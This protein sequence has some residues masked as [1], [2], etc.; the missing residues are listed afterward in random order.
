MKTGFLV[1]SVLLYLIRIPSYAAGERITSSEI[2]NVLKDCALCKPGTTQ[3]RAIGI[4]GGDLWVLAM[5]PSAKSW[6]ML[7][8]SISAGRF[9]GANLPPAA[10]YV[11]LLTAEGS[12]PI[13][14]QRQPVRSRGHQ[15]RLVAIGANGSVSALESAPSDFYPLSRRGSRIVGL[16]PEGDIAM[17]EA[18]VVTWRIRSP[19]RIA[20]TLA[21]VLDSGEVVIADMVWGAIQVQNPSDGSRNARVIEIADVRQSVVEIDKAVSRYP[22]TN[23][24]PLRP[25]VLVASAQGPHGHIFLLTYPYRA[26]EGVKVIE[27]GKTGEYRRTIRAVLPSYSLGAIAY[28]AASRERLCL[29][30]ITGIV[31]C[32]DVAKG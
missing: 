15:G 4:A 29:G 5:D 26:S 8:G 7:R 19:F 28:L 2:L 16:L 9:H 20:S 17:V 31:L 30:T 18:G 25:M 23:P 24:A 3:V 12:S 14:L 21:E 10:S 11:G 6:M 22:R 27:L 1:L 13:T 32:Y